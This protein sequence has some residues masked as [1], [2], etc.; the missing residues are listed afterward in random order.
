M[1]MVGI[2]KRK[3]YRIVMGLI[4]PVAYILTGNRNLPLAIAFFFLLLLL[5]L[6]YERWRH[7]GVWKYLL[8]RSK[9]IF[10][11]QQGILTGDSY[12]MISVLLILVFFQKEV[13]ASALLFLVFGDAGSGIIGTRYGRTKI[14]S[15]K[16]LEGLAGGCLFNIIVALVVFYIL[17]VPLLPLAGGAL[18]ASFMEVLP[19]GI[20]DNLTVGLFSALVM[21]LLLL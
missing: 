6:E 15:G 19:L 16:T 14:F 9:G 17:D 2:L 18:T 3:A 12:F 1:T 20:D 8:N 5:L 13:A 4:F 7:P 21:K 10:K 11:K